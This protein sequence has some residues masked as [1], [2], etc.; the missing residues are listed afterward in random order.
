VMSTQAML[1]RDEGGVERAHSLMRTVSVRLSE[2]LG[3]DH[4]AVMGIRKRSAA[5]LHR[6]QSAPV[7]TWDMAAARSRSHTVSVSTPPRTQ[8]GSVLLHVEAGHAQR[9]EAMLSTRQAHDMAAAR[10]RSH[11][12]SVSTPPR[13]Q[14][15]SVLLHVE[16]GH[17]QRLEAMLSTRQAHDVSNVGSTREA[18]GGVP[19]DTAP[20][21]GS[22]HQLAEGRRA[23]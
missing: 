20:D 18:D 5:H 16:A 15:G 4:H 8:S 7:G 13:T 19:T 11:T 6:M 2:Q 9:L 12:V 1:A 21:D 23:A 10:S 3:E 17:A 22:V 14:S